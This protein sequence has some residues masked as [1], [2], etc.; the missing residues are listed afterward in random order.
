MSL[1]GLP[2]SRDLH[3]GP[4]FLQ[5]PD[6]AEFGIDLLLGLVSDRTGVQNDEIRVFGGIGF[7]I[8]AAVSHQV[9]DPVRI[10]FVHLAAKGFDKDFFRSH[11]FY[12]GAIEKKES[13]C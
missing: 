5:I 4:L 10:V 9:H 12:P 13:F 2:H 3:A 11:G 6:P 8:A 1:P 7:D